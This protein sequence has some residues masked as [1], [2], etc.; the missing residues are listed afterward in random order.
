MVLWQRWN[1]FL[2]TGSAS[3]GIKSFL[4]AYVYNQFYFSKKGTP[5]GDPNEIVYLG[6]I[7][8][9]YDDFEEVIRQF[10]ETT[11]K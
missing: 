2:S 5:L 4:S 6:K 9:S 3:I 10:S 8:L 1:L 7:E 11:F